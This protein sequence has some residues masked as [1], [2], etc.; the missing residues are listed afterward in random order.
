MAAWPEA[1]LSTGAMAAQQ[2]GRLKL[3]PTVVSNLM[4][5]GVPAPV[6]RRAGPGDGGGRRRRLAL[7]SP[8][9]RPL[10]MAVLLVGTF[11]AT[12]YAFAYDLPAETAAMALFIQ[13]RV[14]A[15]RAFSLGEIVV[16]ML[17]L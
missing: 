6:A 8:L 4:L 13:A 15:N 1:L 2:P 16:L 9:S 17:A 5:A 7:L 10:A 14:D 11:L 12:P 3:M